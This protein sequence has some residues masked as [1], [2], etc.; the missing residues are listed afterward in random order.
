MN[1]KLRS[2]CLKYL[3]CSKYNFEYN[4]CARDQGVCGAVRVVEVFDA[5]IHFIIP[6]DSSRRMTPFSDR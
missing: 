6:I 3:R 2:S 1:N 4:Y 5:I